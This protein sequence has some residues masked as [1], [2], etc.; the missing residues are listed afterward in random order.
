MRGYGES[1][2]PSG[3]ENYVM[4]KLDNDLKV[5][6]LHELWTV[7][8]ARLRSTTG[9]YCFNRCLSVHMGVPH[10]H[11]IILPLVPC[12]LQWVYPSDRFQVPSWGVPQHGDT[13]EPGIEYPCRDRTAE[14]V[15]DTRHAVCLLRSRRRTVLF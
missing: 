7:T 13:P 1:D 5:R 8:A 11:P 3:V 14:G 10:L 12:P 9:R 2:K 15:L 6:R 4:E